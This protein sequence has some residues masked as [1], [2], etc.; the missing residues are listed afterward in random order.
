MDAALKKL[1][2]NL[3]EN[4]SGASMSNAKK[5]TDNFNKW[6]DMLGKGGDEQSQSGGGDG[7]GE[8]PEVD[9]ELLLAILRMIQGEQNIRDK[10]RSI[11]KN[12]PEKKEYSEKANRIADEQDDLYRMLQQVMEKVED[13][14][15]AVELLEGAGKAMKDAE[16]M[17]KKPQTDVETIAAETEVIERLSGAFQQSA[18]QQQ[19]KGKPGSKMMAMLMQMLMQQ[20][21]KGK[22]GTKPGEGAGGFSDDPNKR[23]TGP[24]FHKNDP[25][26]NV[27]QTGGTESINLP[28]EYKSA[29]EAFYKKVNE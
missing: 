20:Q 21:G 11:E 23:F 2:D 26:R 3:S 18:K 5:M 10:T 17:L 9:M 15:D 8:P 4:H 7:G 27:D 19:G 13:T 22:P 6:A 28:E 14:P 1:E 24:D 12:K 16:E 29:I 25:D